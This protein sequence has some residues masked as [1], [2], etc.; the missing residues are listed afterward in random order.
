[1]RR[2]A[3]ALGGDEMVLQFNIFRIKAEEFTWPECSTR[4]EVAKAGIE[5]PGAGCPTEHRLLN[6]WMGGKTAIRDESAQ[7]KPW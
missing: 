1:V 2:E 7:A 3:A 4:L 5:L 6:S